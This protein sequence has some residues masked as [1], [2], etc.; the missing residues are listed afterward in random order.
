[1]KA[2]I[3]TTRHVSEIDDYQRKKKILKISN[4][5]A[6]NLQRKRYQRD[7]GFQREHCRQEKLNF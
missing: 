2:L 1:M 5:K 3:R 4:E 6:N 7:I